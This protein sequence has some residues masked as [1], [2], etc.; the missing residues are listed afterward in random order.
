MEINLADLEEQKVLIYYGDEM[1]G[2][3]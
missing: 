3:A 2:I 1:G